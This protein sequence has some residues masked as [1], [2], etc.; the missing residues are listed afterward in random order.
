M[1]RFR[2]HEEHELSISLRGFRGRGKTNI[3]S[4][5][6]KGELFSFLFRYCIQGFPVGQQLF[7]GP[8]EFVARLADRSW[9][10]RDVGYHR[11]LM[12]PMILL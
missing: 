9:L 11:G 12:R 10:S 3:K 4:A 6:Q 2:Y 5:K 1:L 8:N 7:K